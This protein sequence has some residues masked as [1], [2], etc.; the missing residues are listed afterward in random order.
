VD[1]DEV[2]RYGEV[3]AP[4]K[5]GRHRNGAI[6]GCSG[7]VEALSHYPSDQLIC[8]DIEKHHIYALLVRHPVLVEWTISR[9]SGLH[10]SRISMGPALS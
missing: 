1:G 3:E 4:T 10:Y 2:S 6:D 7:M 8:T 9:P 5:L